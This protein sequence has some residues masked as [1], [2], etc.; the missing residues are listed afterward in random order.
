M[1]QRVAKLIARI[2]WALRMLTLCGLALVA[3]C[4]DEDASQPRRKPPSLVDPL[5]EWAFRIYVGDPKQPEKLQQVKLRPVR[6]VSFPAAEQQ[7]GK[8][9]KA[10]VK[11]ASKPNGVI[12]VGDASIGFD[13]DNLGIPTG[14]ALVYGAAAEC[15][16]INETTAPDGLPLN[17]YVREQTPVVPPWLDPTPPLATAVWGIFESKP[18]TCEQSL[19]YSETLLCIANELARVADS[20]SPITWTRVTTLPLLFGFPE[21]P[22][23]IPPQ[24]QKDRFIARDLAIYMLANLALNDGWFT[25]IGSATEPCSAVYA[26]AG[27]DPTFGF[28]EQNW[29][30]GGGDAVYWPPEGSVTTG[31]IPAIAAGRLNAITHILRSGS[32]LLDELID[33]SVEADM[34]GTEK[35]RAHATDEER[36][37]EIAWGRRDNENGKYNTLAHALRVIAGRWEIG[38]YAG[39]D[40]AATF[41]KVDPE[42]GGIPTASLLDD[43]YGDDLTARISDR[44]VRTA[45]QTAAINIVQSA[46]IVVP[47]GVVASNLSGVRAAVKDQLVESAALAS[48]YA[49][50]G[51][52]FT[53]FT[54]TGQGKSIEYVLKDISDGDLTF[55]LNKSFNQYRILTSQSDQVTDVTDPGAGLSN[56]G[57]VADSLYGPAIKGT[58][59]AGGMPKED[60]GTDFMSRIG[61]IQVAGQCDEDGGLFGAAGVGAD[62]IRRAAFQDSYS[63]G[64][65]FYRRLVALREET[66]STWGI[67]DPPADF[68]EPSRLAEGAATEVRAW[69]GPGRMLANS[70]VDTGD[71]PRVREINL[72]LFGFE[73]EDFGASEVSEMP[74]Q[75]A[76]VWG[77]PWVADCAARL[78]S[79][80][81][82]GFEANYV[83]KLKTV[84]SAVQTTAADQREWGFDG[85]ALW[86]K[87]LP[88]T[89]PQTNFHPEQIGNGDSPKNLYVVLL[90]DPKNPT[91]KGRVLG[92]LALRAEAPAGGTSVPVVFKQ[93]SHFDDIFGPP[94]KYLEPIQIGQP[95]MFYGPEYCIN[96]IP[97]DFF[98]PLENE[99]TS[100]SDEYESSWRHYLNLAKNAAIHADELGREVIELGLQQEYR[101]E[102]ANEEL[103]QI[104]G[105]Y[106]AAGKFDTKDGKLTPPADDQ[107]LKDC[108]GEDVYD[109]VFLTNDPT[110]KQG[111]PQEQLDFIQDTLVGCPADDESDVCL[112]TSVNNDL[113]V[114]GNIDT[115]GLGL[116][117]YQPPDPAPDP[118]ACNGVV[119][120]MDS[121]KTGY[122]SNGLKLASGAP[123]LN[124]AQLQSFAK[125]LHVELFQD[126]TT[127][128]PGWTLNYLGSA[129]MSSASGVLWPG[130]R[131]SGAP[132]CDPPAE[133]VVFDK[134]FRRL[135]GSTGT[136][137]GDGVGSGTAEDEAAAILWRLEGALW[138]V[139]AMSGT[140]PG[141]MFS[142]VMP[143]VNFSA[144]GWSSE[145]EKRAPVFTVFGTG[146]FTGG[147][148]DPSG[149]GVYGTDRE[150]LGSGSAIDSDFA[151]AWPP[152]D[153]AP[154]WLYLLYSLS[155]DDK[156]L[157]VNGVNPDITGFKL[158]DT[159]ANWLNKNAEKFLGVKCQDGA[160][161]AVKLV[162]LPDGKFEGSGYNGEDHIIAPVESLRRGSSW[163]KL[164]QN[165]NGGTYL[166]LEMLDATNG[167]VKSE[168]ADILKFEDDGLDELGFELPT[169]TL[170]KG[171]VAPA[172]KFP[173]GILDPLDNSIPSSGYLPSLQDSGLK[174]L[175]IQ[176]Q[177]GKDCSHPRLVGLGQQS[178][179]LQ[180]IYSSC[181]Y[182]QSEPLGA[183]DNGIRYT[184]RMLL[185]Q[186]CSQHKRVQAFVNSYPPRG[187]CSAVAQVTQAVALTCELT[188]GGAEVPL[189]QPDLKTLADLPGFVKWIDRLSVE[190]GRQVSKLYLEKLPRSVVDDF[191]TLKVGSGTLKGD[192]GVLLL[193][194]RSAL[195]TMDSGWNRVSG[196]LAQL[197]DAVDGA[198]L[199][200][201]AAGIAENTAVA[202]LAIQRLSIHAGMVAAAGNVLNVA[203]G[204]FGSLMNVGS[205]L[206]FNGAMLDKT[207]ELEQYAEQT[208]DN[209][210]NMALNQLQLTSGPVYTD[211]Q[212]ALNDVRSSAA[213][214]YAI[215]VK[216]VQS[217]E[218]AKYTAAKAANADYY[219]DAEG[220]VIKL[221]VNTVQRRLY[222]LAQKR[223]WIALKNAK[224]LA[225]VAR[226]AIEQRIGMRL[227][228][229]Q[230]GVGVLEAPAYWADDICSLNGVDFEALKEFDTGFGGEI[231]N[232]A[233]EENDK[234]VGDYVTKL[235]NF[236]EY[237]NIEY[238]SHDG[239]DTTVLSLR[240]DLLGPSQ[241]CTAEAPNL[242]YYSGDLTGYD[243]IDEGGLPLKRG[244]DT[245][246]CGYGD[247][248]CLQVD[249][250]ATLP[251][252][253]ALPPEALTGGFTW[254]HE[255]TQSPPDAGADAGDAEAGVPPPSSSLTPLRTVAQAVTLTAGASYVLS[256]WDQA[257]AA[258]GTYA[259]VDGPDYVAEVIAPDGTTVAS[260]VGKAFRPEVNDAGLPQV[261]D[262]GAPVNQ[263]WSVRNPLP[264]KADQSGEYRVVFGAASSPD[265]G[266]LGSVL[267]ANVQLEQAPGGSKPSGY[268][269]TTSSRIYVTSECAG[270]SPEDLQKAFSYGCDKDGKCF[271]E[272]T[273]PIVIDTSKVALSRLAGKLA[274][275]NFNFRHIDLA[276]NVV[277]TGVY[278]CTANPSQ[279]CFASAYVEYTLDH[280]AFRVGVLNHFGD[281]QTFNFGSAGINH[282]KALAAERYI[283]LP[284]ASAD[285]GLLFQPGVLKPEY[286]GRPLDGSYRLRIWDSPFLVWNRLED[287][288]L[289]LKYRYWSRIEP[290]PNQ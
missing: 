218:K 18:S 100:D 256:W 89:S 104:C 193:E 187:G 239:D 184:R 215:Q 173:L 278:D 86:L 230:T 114:T 58:A 223:Y 13:E 183:F 210:V 178:P 191:N 152:A 116:G 101:S 194:L 190:A 81:P 78:R 98:V 68:D 139:G 245:N 167:I 201:E 41:Y 219:V 280:D 168:F 111:T 258:D 261:D 20:L 246:T 221:P 164:C 157:H 142:T 207:E 189:T 289:V 88:L 264:F 241:A 185:P 251:N 64:Q 179:G 269:H 80:C 286:R 11:P 30:F 97:K 132:L 260:F 49:L 129:R 124:G 110:A 161:G 209:T 73:K 99:L 155:P 252:P 126:P 134:L 235:E 133:A 166:T 151:D 131:R 12:E 208:K 113:A 156:Y 83:R 22:W 55:A 150:T 282:A 14:W 56:A 234:F 70:K 180:F 74:D 27:K 23:T 222:D 227:N 136:T 163:G 91:K 127:G 15:G 202:Q 9:L 205:T 248:K 237:Y 47:P 8:L 276:M 141:K 262:A 94:P 220:Q 24:T 48:G 267:I 95:G 45:G 153:E 171:L 75:I 16:M 268:I 172:G 279:S 44:S 19:A 211:L 199:G 125:Q 228:T 62:T 284:I 259:T 270:K 120:L 255:V 177:G 175:T 50:T 147:Q 158:A 206:Y 233:A 63:I 54:T 105:D 162:G 196:D 118:G 186:S 238:P 71:P 266:L 42:C 203:G 250:E 77:E 106:G 17:P 265:P 87:F 169:W 226:L 31:S 242:L 61:R 174:G 145:S 119:G 69:T 283:T 275:G 254:L 26:K 123:Y 96:G 281:F 148:L 34:A 32:R 176:S 214:V 200:I 52:E 143:A 82:P 274:A 53:T 72:L 263:I 287:L 130:C 128:V 3:S 224:Y 122:D 285:E 38:G 46:G 212:N 85:A 197:R 29:I 84:V 204:D 249:V 90:N 79:S 115:A 290:Q 28:N 277:G 7:A 236:V 10:E 154:G 57:H 216:L 66:Q 117:E 244:W 2:P 39:G 121:L 271:Y 4:G 92:A 40:T 67:Y 6:E 5:S 140:V 231:E 213:T 247:P 144:S 35:R 107:N 65:T 135:T 272:L 165:G 138:T 102:A 229:I 240:D 232:D 182:D 21:G 25:E 159:V 225:Y 37:S 192:H 1:E 76:L 112:A 149:S 273:T 146:I 253:P 160:T 103:A 257:R 93:Q 137:L 108:L 36:G 43:A 198:R 170:S 195:E 33:A 60:F 109:I 59:L 181:A 188:A 51:Q 217:Q 288:Q 243:F